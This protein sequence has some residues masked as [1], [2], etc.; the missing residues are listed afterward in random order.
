MYYLFQFTGH[1]TQVVWKES[2]IL[3]VGEA[4]SASGKRYVVAR[5]KPRGNMMGNF[6]AN[7][8]RPLSGK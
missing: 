7:V 8:P 1:F 2:I 6:E 4:T 3:G 5:Y